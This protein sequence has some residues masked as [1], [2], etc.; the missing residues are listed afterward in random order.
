[1]TLEKRMID[2]TTEAI[3]TEPVV[4]KKEVYVETKVVTEEIVWHRDL[5]ESQIAQ[6]TNDI[7]NLQ[8]EIAWLQKKL[9]EIVALSKKK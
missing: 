1:M 2:Y 3:W 6:K 5:I 8:I 7:E 9:D 4:E